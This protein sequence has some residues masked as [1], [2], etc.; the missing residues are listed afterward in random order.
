MEAADRLK[1]LILDIETTPHTVDVWDLWN[2]NVGIN[3]IHE[4][5]H[6]LSFAAK[7]LGASTVTYFDM[8]TYDLMI[9]GAHSLVHDADVV[10]GYNHVTFDM[11]H[12]NRE[13][14]LHDY[15][16]P[17]PYKT[18]DLLRIIKRTFK[19]ASNKLGYVTKALGLETKENH[20]GHTLWVKCIQGDPEAWEKMRSYNIQD[21]K[22]TEALYNRVL[23]WI[24]G[25]PNVA[26]VNGQPDGCPKCGVAGQLNKQGYS[27]TATGRFQRFKCGSCGS[28]STSGK[29]IEGMDLR[30]V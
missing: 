7:W 12:L 10:V 1:T 21:V 18:V 19:F 25:H 15:A 29:R 5:T 23:P 24:P 3:Q 17:A 8:R 9:D 22:I 6:L 26:L 14:L 20:E 28:W 30:N 4:P 11:P 13:F 2:Q 27:Y 16:P